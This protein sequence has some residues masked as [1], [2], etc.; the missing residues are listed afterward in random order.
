MRRRRCCCCSTSSWPRNTGVEGR[1][2]TGTI[3]N[4]VLKEYIARGTYIFPP[5]PSLRLVSDTFAYCREYLPAWNSISISGYHMAEAGAT[6]AQEVAFTLAN[7]GRLRGGRVGRRPDRRPVRTAAV[8]L[9]RFP[10]HAAGGDRQ[11]P[12]RPADLGRLMRDHFGASDPKSAML[13]FHTQTAGVQLTAQQPE[14]EPRPGHRPSARGRARRHPVA[15]HQL[16][17]RGA[18]AADREGG[19]TGPAHPAGAGLRDRPDRRPSTRS[20][21]RTPSSPSPTTWRPRWSG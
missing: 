7:G 15:A 16:L 9:L 6:P 11:V 4:D 2:L 13:R 12:G 20:P 19:P 14:V 5:A 8:V 3:Q 18:R 1:Q 10:D 21:A 17:R